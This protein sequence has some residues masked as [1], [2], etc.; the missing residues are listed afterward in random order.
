MN[1]SPTLRRLQAAY[2]TR[3]QEQTKTD[4]PRPCGNG[5]A[6]MDEAKV[7]SDRREEKHETN[8]PNGHRWSF[9]GI[10]H[11]VPLG[12]AGTSGV[13]WEHM[14]CIAPMRANA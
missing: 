1:C 3:N 4:D 14:R 10:T 5:L 9:A 8:K 13:P 11:R 12:S 6:N 2:S 7:R